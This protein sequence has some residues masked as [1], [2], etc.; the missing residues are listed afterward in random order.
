MEIKDKVERNKEK[1]KIF[2]NN[3]IR[4]FIQDVNSNYFF[5]DITSVHDDFIEVIGFVGKRKFER[6]RIYY[7]DII[8]FE[9]YEERVGG[10]K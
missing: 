10:V 6:D 7:V 9:E 1:A 4:A 3:K 2:L 8:R 5:C